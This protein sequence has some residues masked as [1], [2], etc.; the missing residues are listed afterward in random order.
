[1][2]NVESRLQM[3]IQVPKM[4]L[5]GSMHKAI[6][7]RPQPRR[8]GGE[9]TMNTQLALP[10]PTQTNKH[11]IKLLSPTTVRY[12]DGLQG[13]STPCTRIESLF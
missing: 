9:N 6:P 12:D 5:C 10:K 2:E 13:G 7:P 11:T 8:R 1:M 4:L 3:Q